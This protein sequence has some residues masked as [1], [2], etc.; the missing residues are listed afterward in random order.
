MRTCHLLLVFAISTCDTLTHANTQK[1][2]QYRIAFFI[3]FTHT[4]RKRGSAMNLKFI[5]QHCTRIQ[6]VCADESGRAVCGM[7]CL[8]SFESWFRG[9]ESHSKVWMSVFV[10]SCIQAA[11]LRRADHSFKESYC[12]R[13]TR[14]RNWRRGNGCGATDEWMNSIY[15]KPNDARRFLICHRIEAMNVSSQFRH[16]ST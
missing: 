6:S 11:A 2:T 12:L 5:I 9:F 16:P 14:L 7:N 4:H 8:R 10:L 1:N 3:D 13:K 15:K